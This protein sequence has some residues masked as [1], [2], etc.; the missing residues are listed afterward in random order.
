M[1]DYR[2]IFQDRAKDY[3][4][5]MQQFPNV[6]SNE[7]DRLIMSTDF[8]TIH[9]ILDVPAGGGYLKKFVPSGVN[10]ISTD[11]SEGFSNDNIEFVSPEKLPFETNTFDAV[12]SLSGMHHLKNV[13]LFI[14][15]CLRV[16]KN[17]RDF[18]FADV[19]KGS[20]VDVFLNQ[21]V[22]KYNSQGHEGNFFYEDY[23]KNHP[24]IQK[25]IVECKYNE[26]P[27]V[28]NTKEEMILFFKLFFGLDKAND[29]VIFEGIQDILGLEYTKTGI[30]VN[31]GLIRY[32]IIKK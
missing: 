4:F 16:V 5:A 26:Y 29:V 28:F 1:N 24:N 31:W 14:E 25:N 6:R 21:F 30:E 19:K 27:F 32:K 20:S 10:V 18:V 17:N 11:F 23:F 9:T 8:S 2:V 7:F 22:N 12:F 15:E 3:H 13:P